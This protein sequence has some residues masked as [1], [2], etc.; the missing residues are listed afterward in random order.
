MCT[1]GIQLHLVPKIVVLAAILLLGSFGCATT[2]E[3]PPKNISDACEILKEKEDWYSALEDAEKK[4]FVP[5]HV[6]LAIIY[7]ESSFVAQAENAASSAS[8]YA[9]ALSGTWEDYKKSTG[10]AGAS[11]TNFYDAVDFIGWYI[12]LNSKRNSVHPWD[13]FRQYL[14]YH[15]GPSGFARKTYQ[16]KSFLKNKAFK[17]QQVAYKY[18]AQLRLCES[19]FK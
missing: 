15:E 19:K 4:W 13:T 9:Q 8:G 11:R 14:A 17:A 7:V 5:P 3:P 1:T 16:G 18:G 12:S 10:N 2:F 6:V